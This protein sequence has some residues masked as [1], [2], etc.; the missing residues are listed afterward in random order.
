M[1]YK[2]YL[3][4]K[5]EKVTG[6]MVTV[7]NAEKWAKQMWDT[8]GFDYSTA[9]ITSNKVFIWPYEVSMKELKD[10]LDEE[11][12]TYRDSVQVWEV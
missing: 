10:G 4:E 8:Y 12:I 3:N 9:S 5:R 1:G 2:E 11:G 7:P 6:L